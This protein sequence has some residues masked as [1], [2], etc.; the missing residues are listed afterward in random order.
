MQL[1]AEVRG[2]GVWVPSCLCGTSALCDGVWATSYLCGICAMCA[3]AAPGL[4][5]LPQIMHNNIHIMTCTLCGQMLC[6][7]GLVT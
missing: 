2:T 5:V 1:S 6:S 7:E 3:S 4:C